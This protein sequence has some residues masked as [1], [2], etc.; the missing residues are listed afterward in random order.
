[1]RAPIPG[2]DSGPTFEAF[3]RRYFSDL[4]RIELTPA[5]VN[6]AGVV[7]KKFD[8]V[9]A[10]GRYVGDAKWYKNIP[11][12]AAKWS[13]ISEYVWLLQ[14]VKA[15]KVFI[16]FGNDVEVVERYLVRFEPLIRPVEF[17]FLDGSGHR[18]LS[19]ER[20]GPHRRLSGDAGA[21]AS[22]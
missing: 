7:P 1:M 16:V 9:S 17:Y 22:S 11:V 3:A 14:Q 8:L 12:P 4:W 15:E 5:S 18:R 13:T 21:E 10:D 2:V 20:D 6:V 19:L